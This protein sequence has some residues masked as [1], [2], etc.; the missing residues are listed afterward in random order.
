MTAT[1]IQPDLRRAR[2]WNNGRKG[3]AQTSTY[4]DHTTQFI[5]QDAMVKLPTTDFIRIGLTILPFNRSATDA[6][7]AGEEYAY[8]EKSSGRHPT[9]TTSPSKRMPHTATISAG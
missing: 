9:N 5:V 1:S 7:S 4:S 3:A 6:S 8:G 2:L